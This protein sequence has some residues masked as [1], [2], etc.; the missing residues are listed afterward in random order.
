MPAGQPHGAG[1]DSLDLSAYTSSFEYVLTGPGSIDGSTGVT[2][3]TPY[4]PI[5]LGFDNINL[6]IGNLLTDELTGPDSVNDWV[7]TGLNSGT[8]NGV[9]FSAVQI[10]SVQLS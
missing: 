4:N 5:A 1:G 3:G 10:S 9:Q 8:V 6:L 7:I 2:T